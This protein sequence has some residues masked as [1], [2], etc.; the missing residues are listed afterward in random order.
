[1][2]SAEADLLIASLA[3]ASAFDQVFECDL[4]NIRSPSM[5]KYSILGNIVVNQ[6]FGQAEH[7]SVFAFQKTHYSED[8]NT[9][10]SDATVMLTSGLQG[11]GSTARPAER[12]TDAGLS[13]GQAIGAGLAAAWRRA[14]NHEPQLIS[15]G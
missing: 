15:L 9:P 5:R 1:L 6:V 3:L 11:S 13:F 14:A 2:F 8:V 4:L 10:S 7:A 12:R